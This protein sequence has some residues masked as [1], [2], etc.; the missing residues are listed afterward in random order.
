M[1]LDN[2]RAVVRG[3]SPL[4]RGKHPRFISHCVPFGL[5]PAHAGKTGCMAAAPVEHEAHP[6][7]RGENPT[8]A[9][10]SPMCA[11]SSPL[12]RGK[13][14]MLWQ[15]AGK[16]RL[17]PA[18]AGKTGEPEK[19]TATS[20]AHPRSRGENH[21][22]STAALN[23]SGS[24]PLTRGKRN[25][26]RVLPR[27]RRLIPAHAGKTCECIEMLGQ[28]WAHPR[29]RGENGGNGASQ[30]DSNGSSPLTRGKHGGRGPGC[31]WRRLIP[32]HAGKTSSPSP[33][34]PR[35]AA[36]PR[37]RGENRGPL[38]RRGSTIGSSPLTRGKLCDWP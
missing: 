2:L 26:R 37:S 5:I 28:A 7:S 29:S 14:D 21:A 17:I 13:R 12:T 35:P 1:R 4:T 22:A 10:K 27:A 36:H 8:F 25:E 20:T 31:G 9:A 33:R 6:R 19:L 11:G 18:H 23:V 30:D 24:S 34:S 38:R 3:S 16:T 15:Q 32:A